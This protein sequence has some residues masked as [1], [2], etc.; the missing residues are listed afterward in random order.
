VFGPFFQAL[1]NNVE[2]TVVHTQRHL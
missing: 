1:N 2:T